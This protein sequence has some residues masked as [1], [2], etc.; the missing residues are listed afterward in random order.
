MDGSV[1]LSTEPLRPSRNARLEREEI[2]T[3][4]FKSGIL[5]LRHDNKRQPKLKI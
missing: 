1:S 2:T 5:L 4:M 3:E